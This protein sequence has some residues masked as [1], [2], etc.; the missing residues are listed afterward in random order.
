M[1]L[2]RTLE[3]FDPAASRRGLRRAGLALQIGT[4][5]GLSDDELAST[6]TA[7]H[8]NEICL[9]VTHDRRSDTLN[10]ARA[11]LS[12]RVLRSAGLHSCADAVHH[13]FER[14]GGGGLPVGLSGRDIPTGARVLAAVGAHDEPTI[15]SMGWL[16]P[17]LNDALDAVKATPV[18]PPLDLGWLDRQLEALELPETGKGLSVSEILEASQRT[19]DIIELIAEHALEQL[20][21]SSVSIARFDL[22]NDQLRVVINAG[23]LG[24]HDLRRP[25]E[26][27][28]PLSA[29]PEALAYQA[30]AQRLLSRTPTTSPA[31][32]RYLDL[33]GLSSEAVVPIID[34]ESSA[35]AWGIVW[36][37]TYSEHNR[38]LAPADLNQ[39]RSIADDLALAIQRADRF[40]EFENLALRDPLTGLWNRRILDES[41]A[42]I[43]SEYGP[44]EDAA[45]I[46][47]DVDELKAVNDNLGHSA[48]DNVLIEAANSLREATMNLPGVTVCRIGG[49]E[50]AVVIQS[51]GSEYADAIV[52]Q[53]LRRFRR[54]DPNR[55]MSCGVAL[56]N[57]TMSKPGE[58][59]KAAD[60]AQYERKRARKARLGIEFRNDPGPPGTRRRNRRDGN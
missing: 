31:T 18:A 48:G 28:Y 46:I 21:A 37:T 25:S 14:W 4:R 34:D 35:G 57:S 30:G 8:L 15:A 47:C 36:A 44:A 52:E 26:E 19:I 9:L 60:E 40:T 55:S 45:V 41:L 39:L 49:D 17:D 23:S 5:V 6:I 2:A 1:A 51:N 42:K 50:F 58:L 56:T 29:L 38:Q 11:V 7:A 54:D 59:M 22:D 27:V 24:E 32:V 16:E 3:T 33:R 43:F 20:R 53:A 12:S 13:E 10:P